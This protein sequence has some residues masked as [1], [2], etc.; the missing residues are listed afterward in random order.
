METRKFSKSDWEAFSGAEKTSRGDEPRIND[1]VEVAGNGAVLVLDANGIEI[2]EIFG[3]DGETRTWNKDVDFDTGSAM[4]ATL[5]PELGSVA[6]HGFGFAV[7]DGP[8]R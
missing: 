4:V 6:L 8:G 3:A 5:P 1:E 2:V 7:I